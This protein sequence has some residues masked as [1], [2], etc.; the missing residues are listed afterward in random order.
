MAGFARCF[1][2]DE[3]LIRQH[4][5]DHSPAAVATAYRN[6]L[7]LLFLPDS[8]PLSDPQTRLFPAFIPVHSFV[9]S[10]QAVSWFASSLMQQQAFQIV[11]LSHFK[12][13]GVVGRGN[14]YGAGSLCPDPGYGSAINGNFSSY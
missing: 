10:G 14:L 5:L 12:V 6:D 8:P 1:H 4:G 3:P 7:C 13:V 9:F 11:S 2:L